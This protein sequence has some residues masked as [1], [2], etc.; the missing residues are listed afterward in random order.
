MGKIDDTQFLEK[1]LLDRAR[2]MDE[3]TKTP[4]PSAS[5]WRCIENIRGSNLCYIAYRINGIS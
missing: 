5:G 4:L 3:N 1:V 2:K